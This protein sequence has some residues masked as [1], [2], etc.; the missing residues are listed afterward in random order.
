MTRA[1]KTLL[2]ETC[3]CLTTVIA[4]PLQFTQADEIWPQWRGPQ[5][6]SDELNC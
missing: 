5:G 2:F 3:I 1:T 6:L 4:L